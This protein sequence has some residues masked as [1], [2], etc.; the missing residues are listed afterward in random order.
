MDRIWGKGSAILI[1]YTEKPLAAKIGKAGDKKV[2]R[3][4]CFQ[5]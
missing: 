3:L 4:L 1:T 2:V 5:M